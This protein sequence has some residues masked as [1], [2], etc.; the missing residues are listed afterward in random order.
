MNGFV[1][2]KELFNIHEC[3]LCNIY[4]KLIELH[5]VSRIALC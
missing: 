4:I 5:C 2:L 1:T 3:T